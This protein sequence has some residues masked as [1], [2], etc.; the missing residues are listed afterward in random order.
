MQFDERFRDCQSETG[1]LMYFGQLAL[2]LLEGPAEAAQ[3]FLCDSYARI[4]DREGYAFAGRPSAHRD[5]T[6]CRREF[7]R[8]RKQVENDLLEGTAIGAQAKLRR[9]T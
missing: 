2:D 8:I 9:D 5:A 6:M 4:G 7:D 1:T 3:R